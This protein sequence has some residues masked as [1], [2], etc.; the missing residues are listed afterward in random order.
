MA[1]LR[2]SK[3]E[4]AVAIEKIKEV[5]AAKSELQNILGRPLMISSA[6][7]S[8]LVAPLARKRPEAAMSSEQQQEVWATCL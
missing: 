7:N 2:L 8:S 1:A 5:V 3:S 6:S 4:A